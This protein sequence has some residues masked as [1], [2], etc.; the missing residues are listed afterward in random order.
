MTAVTT[1]IYEIIMNALAWVIPPEV[2][3]FPTS[4]FIINVLMLVGGLY[5]FYWILVKP[6]VIFFRS[7]RSWSIRR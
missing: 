2:L 6:F 4:Q 7:L 1:P 3:A 5:V